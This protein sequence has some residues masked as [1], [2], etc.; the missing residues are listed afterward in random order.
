MV[1]TERGYMVSKGLAG[2]L[3]KFHSF[4][5][6]E[7]AEQ[8]GLPD[9]ILVTPETPY[10]KRIVYT[11]LEF[12]DL[13]DSSNIM[14]SDWIKI[15]KTIEEN[16]R[17]YDAFIVLHGTDTIAY[18]ASALSFMLENLNK[19]VI[20][21]GSQIPLLELKNDAVDN[22]LG[23]LLVAGHY[24]IPEVCVFFANKLLR[25]NR[26]TK[27]STIEMTAFNTPN[28]APLGVM[29]VDFDISWEH[30]QRH[31]YDGHINAFSN[32]T[33]SISLLSISPLLNLKIVETILF[34]SKAV[35][36]QAYGMGNI[37]SNNK[38]LMKMMKEAISQDIIVVILT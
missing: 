17:L 15:A 18:T 26:V 21:T 13:I 1:K 9:N 14:V 33:N 35:I 11:M 32:M 12:D 8:L 25:G 2:R 27:E 22:L 30:I 24:I 7:F 5:D 29:G 19:T 28:F 10:H 4:Y 20:I 36:I 16:Y 38:D 6:D 31:A 37:P 23:S 34:Q 3:K